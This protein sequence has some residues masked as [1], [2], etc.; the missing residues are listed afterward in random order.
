M[1]IVFVDHGLSRQYR[2]KLV[3]ADSLYERAHAPQLPLLSAD[4]LDPRDQMLDVP[5]TS[6]DFSRTS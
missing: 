3:V 2:N 6:V 1:A 4:R 5:A